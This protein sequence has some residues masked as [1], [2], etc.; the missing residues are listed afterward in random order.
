MLQPQAMEMDI[1]LIIPN[2]G[3]KLQMN[4]EE[5]VNMKAMEPTGLFPIIVSVTSLHPSYNRLAEL[6]D[7]SALEPKNIFGW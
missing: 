4:N 6:S 2:G 3:K 7:A 1:D 5:A